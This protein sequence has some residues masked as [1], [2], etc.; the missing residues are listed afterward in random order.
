MPENR[1]FVW[2]AVRIGFYSLIVLFILAVITTIMTI[3]SIGID[4]PLVWN[5]ALLSI[6][7]II[8]VSIFNAIT[9]VIH[10][11]KYKDK[12]LAVTS[13]IVSTLVILL[14][15]LSILIFSGRPA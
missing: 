8:P 11:T 3:G 9:S 6:I 1:G 12:A 5:I 7:L 10:L 13:L 2:K 14:I 15:F 4:V